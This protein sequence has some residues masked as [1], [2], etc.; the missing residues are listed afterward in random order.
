MIKCIHL[1]SESPR[2][3]L[4]LKKICLDLNIK[5]FILKANP[6]V[7][8][9]E[10]EKPKLNEKPINY[11]KRVS[12][13]KALT[14]ESWVKENKIIKHPILTGD[15]IVCFE[16][17]ILL[18]PNCKMEAFEMLKTLS[19]NKHK[20]ISSIVLCFP[21]AMGNTPKI[22]QRTVSTTVWFTKIPDKWILKYTRTNEPMDKSGAYAIQ[23]EASMFIKKING[24]YSSV[25]GL[26]MTETRELLETS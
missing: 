12:L 14:A 26:P 21:C 20:V 5:M 13:K 17:K 7:N 18:K 16:N 6:K 10:F 23:G 22:K 1:A 8:S 4:L 2:R 25:V 24:S 3:K 15:T 11:V 9:R 19:D